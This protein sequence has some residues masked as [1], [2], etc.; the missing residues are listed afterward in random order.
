VTTSCLTMPS[1]D[2]SRATRVPE[3]PEGYSATDQAECCN[4]CSTL[5]HCTG[6]V[7]AP[8]QTKPNIN[9]YLMTGYIKPIPSSAGDRVLGRVNNFCGGSLSVTMK[10]NNLEWTPGMFDVSNLD[11]TVDAL[12]CQTTAEDCV[13]N[14][15]PSRMLNGILSKD[16]WYVHDDT[17]VPRYEHSPP[18]YDEWYPWFQNN[19]TNVKDLYFFGY[20]MDYKKSLYDFSLLSGKITMP[21]LASFGV[22]WSRWYAYSQQQFEEEIMKGYHDHGL[23]LNVVVFDMDW[24]ITEPHDGCNTWG[25]FTW[26]KKLFPDPNQFIS[27]LHSSNNSVGHPLKLSLNLHP[28]VGVDHCQSKY[29]EFAKEL[30]FDA[31]TQKTIDIDM[32]NNTVSDA[33]FKVFLNAKELNAVDY[34]WT[35]GWGSGGPKGFELYWQNY[36]Y[37]AEIQRT[38][39]RPL[40]LSR[41]GGIGS[42]RYPIGFSGDTM[43]TFSHLNWQIENTQRAANVLYGYWSH[44]IGGF[45]CVEGCPPPGTSNPRSSTGAEMLLRWYQ[46]GA[47]SPMFRTHCM[48]CERRIWLFPYYELI[49]DAMLFRNS[50]VPYL[51]TM[52]RFAYERAISIVYPIYY[53]F[54]HDQR[55]YDYKAQYM[56]GQDILASPITSLIDSTSVTIEWTTWLPPTDAAW[57]DWNGTNIFKPDSVVVA[58]Y[59]RGDIPLFAKSG[60]VVPMRSMNDITSSSADPSIWVIFPGAS[61]Y[62]VLYEDD[63]ESL[64]YK[65]DQFSTTTL[66]HNR[67]KSLITVVIDAAKG[68]FKGIKTERS[69]KLQ[70]RGISERVSSVTVNGQP[71]SASMYYINKV[72]SLSETVG[73]LIITLPK[74]STS[75]SIMV[76]IKLE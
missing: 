72:H 74:T 27:S 73:S 7:F 65:S 39:K 29:A 24:H 71:L 68:S 17:L 62:G 51:Y 28:Q 44:D 42:H 41:Y 19:N 76:E 2:T 63:G 6:W 32:A 31:S 4:M 1:Y 16:G 52:A 34:W 75:K 38:G 64:G 47:V 13:K 5:N 57:V 12:D 36:V 61:G 53:D 43:Q 69:H 54:P 10:S 25:G 30:G 60:S 26:D 33:Y 50:L 67:D 23:P 40:V 55:S 14:V 22:W 49:K 48:Q 45:K 8:K 11:G 3:Y 18:V 9:C 37:D 35:D 46:F 70:L 66:K 56:F 15:Y 58:K 21:P 59:S 20:G